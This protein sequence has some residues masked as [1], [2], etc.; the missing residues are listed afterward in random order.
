MKKNNKTNSDS[1]YVYDACVIG[2]GASGLVCGAVLARRGMNTLII[3]Q[4]KKS[5]RKLYATGNGKCNLANAVISD[6][7]YYA[8]GFAKEVVTEG[9]AL[10]LHRYLEQA[11]IPLTEK[12]G[13]YYP[14]S[15]QASSVVWA[16]TD[17]AKLAGCEFA[18]E[19]E[20]IG[21]Q[22]TPEGGFILK[23]RNNGKNAGEEDTILCNRLV[24][25]MGSPAAP[26]LGSGKEEVICS[27]L[28][29]LGL[30][31]QPFEPALC[32]LE[33]SE[34]VS[35]LAGVRV[36]ARISI[37]LAMDRPGFGED[38]TEE[39]ELMLTEYGLSG[40]VIFNMSTMVQKGEQVS[41]DLLPLWEDKEKWLEAVRGQEQKR[42]LFGVLNGML[43]EK[44]C[45]YFIENCFGEKAAKRPV[46]SYTDEELQ[47]LFLLLKDW[48]LTV[49][50]KKADMGQ[51][52][53]GGVLTQLLSPDTLQVK[54]DP[55]IAV[56]GELTQ[57][58][59]RC[60]GYNLMY[61]MISGIRAGQRL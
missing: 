5:G 3:E 14:Q 49:T 45:R 52:C 47:Q 59:G 20:V 24:L 40:I 43:H 53:R 50:G 34:D 54:R 44:L 46:S 58:T 61:A 42:T 38:L 6:S 57:V 19:T 18:Y 1:G 56:I 27:L 31:Y 11:G 16:L 33:V 15:L 37:G 7:A 51:A 36:R 30:G 13:Y 4:N 60:G 23:V 22:R 28:D 25:A 41:V 21:I 48:R 32:P 39:G 9:S 10:F 35:A 2:A 8:S 17:G 12:N 26:H 55:R 29:E